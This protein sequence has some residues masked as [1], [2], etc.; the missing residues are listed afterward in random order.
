ML[1]RITLSLI[2]IFAICFRVV[3]GADLKTPLERDNYSH[4]TSNSDMMQYLKELDSQSKFMEMEIIG[5]SAKG[6]PIPALYFSLDNKFASRR[7]E[8]P[9]VL[10]FCQQH[11]D[12]PSG[13]EA[14]LVLARELSGKSKSLLSKLDL[15][16]VPQMNPDGSEAEKRENGNGMDLNRNHVILSEPEV[17]AVH[18]LF[19]KWMPEVTLDVHEYGALSKSW[20][21]HGFIKD[22]DEQ[23]GGNTNLNISPRI[24]QYTREHFLPAVGGKIEQAGFTFHRYIV[25]SP[26]EGSRVRFSTTAVNDGR[27]SMGIYNTMSFI[28]EG[29]QYG[30]VLD[31]IQ[32][33]TEGQLAG[34]VSF[35]ETISENAP[36]IINLVDS[37]RQDLLQKKERALIQM[38][39]YPDSTWQKLPFPV[40]DLYSWKHEEK[41]L[42]N[43]QPLVKAQK[44]VARPM[45]Y[46]IPATESRLI[47]LLQKHHIEMYRLTADMSIEVESY[48][49]LHVTSIIEEEDPMP[50]VDLET[51]SGSRQF[52]SGTFVVFLKQSANNLLPLIL[53]PESSFSIAGENSGRKY[54]F[55]EYLQEG[56]TYPICRMMKETTLKMEKVEY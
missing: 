33:R 1:N 6:L 9:L 12:E 50:Y 28:M 53:E 56:S 52:E 41:E 25:G 35:L 27:Q 43:F 19:L 54:R 42:E 48:K 30:S 26:F 4:L 46:I 15:I 11:G 23:I 2:M 5:H 47:K 32:H 16:L 13:K 18:A 37:A 10:I 44:S 17:A 39:Y 21:S 7:A 45:A 14:A 3:L 55:K 29:K 40:F 51:T 8:K 31:E 20:I 36:Q 22:A 24:I 38:D 34:L 49:I